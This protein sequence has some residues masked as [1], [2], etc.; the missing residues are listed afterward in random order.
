MGGKTAKGYPVPVE[1]NPDDLPAQQVFP[2]DQAA[3]VVTAGD[4]MDMPIVRT[5]VDMIQ[6]MLGHPGAVASIRDSWQDAVGHLT[7]ATDGGAGGNSLPTTMADLG[8]YWDGRGFNAAKEYVTYVTSTT[9]EVTDIIV[10]I[11]KEIDKFRSQIMNCYG[12]A[13]EH[14]ANCAAIVV[15]LAG[16]VITD[17][18]T[19]NFSG[20]CTALVDALTEFIKE[21]GKVIRDIIGYRSDA[22]TAV[23]N[24]KTDA[25][26]LRTVAPIAESALQSRNWSPKPAG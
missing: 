26:N 17:F 22:E 18:F 21:A 12:Q 3:A 11:A 8:F 10:K 6:D 5:Y 13:I 25:K 4:R 24:L 14:I 19:A 1:R 16:D 15:R 20:I 2:W 23:N 9:K 7:K